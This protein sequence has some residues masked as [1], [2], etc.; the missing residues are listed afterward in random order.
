[1]TAPLPPLS[2]ADLDFKTAIEVDGEVGL[3]RL[4]FDDRFG[5]KRL[6]DLI[7]EAY[8]LELMVIAQVVRWYEIGLTSPQ[9]LTV[10]HPTLL[11]IDLRK[12][13][14]ASPQEHVRSD[15]MDYTLCRM[16]SWWKEHTVTS[17]WRSLKAHVRVADTPH[18][19]A[20]ALADFIWDARGL[21]GQI[22]D[23]G[24]P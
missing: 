6:H 23:G 19:L 8:V 5:R 20:D 22:H 3:K 17:A 2:A 15:M 12:R 14:A 11:M 4:G 16:W 24:C 10:V 13:I 18:D 21:L 7:H 1:M 9:E